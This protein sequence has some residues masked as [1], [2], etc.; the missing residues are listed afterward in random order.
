MVLNPSVE[1]IDAETL[2]LLEQLVQKLEKAYSEAVDFLEPCLPL[3][4]PLLLLM[5]IA[6]AHGRAEG[7]CNYALRL[8]RSLSFQVQLIPDV[9]AVFDRTHGIMAGPVIEGF[10]HLAHACYYTQT[11]VVFRQVKRE[12]AFLF[13]IA[14]GWEGGFEEIYSTIGNTFWKRFEKEQELGLTL[15]E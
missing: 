4:E 5:Q 7:A 2:G 3:V 10:V 13:Q 8:L 12:A 9:G 14:F 1:N 11:E 6:A 15:I